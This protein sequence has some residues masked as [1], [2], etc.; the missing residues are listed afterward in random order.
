MALS[1]I[2]AFDRQSLGW[3]KQETTFGT[4]AKPAATEQFFIAGAG[5]IVQ[6]LGFIEDQQRRNTYSMLK[7]FAGRF[8]PGTADIPVYLKPSGTVD[9]APE[10]SEFLIGLFGRESV[11]AAT[12]VDY[13]LNRVTDTDRSF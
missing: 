11:T 3:I 5:K 6:Q 9:V 8:D 2:L 7:R 13:L 1:D 4:Q 10:A 12:K